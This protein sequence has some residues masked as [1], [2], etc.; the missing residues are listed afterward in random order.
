[1]KIIALPDLH[2][3]IRSLEL[4]DSVYS[5]VDLILLVED[6]TTKGNEQEA[7]QAVEVLRTYHKPILAIPGNW[8][9]PGVEA[10]LTS[11]GINLHRKVRSFDG[12]QFAGLGGS[13]HSP[14]TTLFEMSESEIEMALNE[15]TSAIDN[16]LPLIFVCHQPPYDTLLDQKRTGNHVGSHSVRKWIEQVQPMLCLTGH[17]HEGVGVDRVVNTTIVNPGP[18]EEG[19]YALVQ[20]SR[21]GIQKVNLFELSL[22]RLFDEK[23]S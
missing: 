16:Q 19:K 20:V 6:I 21:E 18:T 13:I 22:D 4:L 10:Y 14:S 23:N 7:R 12:F 2:G 15:M 8:D 1:M 5:D 3:N 17:I 9:S 11:E